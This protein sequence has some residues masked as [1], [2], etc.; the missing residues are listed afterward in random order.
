MDII[1]SIKNIDTELF[2]FL[3]SKHSHF[4]DVAMYWVT[5]RFF[6]IP[7]YL[8]LFYLAFKQVGKRIWLLAIFAALLILLSDQLSVHAF[9]NVFLR[10]RPCHNLLIQHQVHLLNGHCGG[11]YGFISSHATNTFALAMFLFLF[12]KNKMKRFGIFI[13]TWATVVSYSR[14]Y[15]GVH[16]PADLAVGA[17]VGMG[18][19]ISVFK[20]Y[21]YIDSIL[22]KEV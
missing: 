18:I 8:F 19:G 9:K 22:M 21:Y 3:N 10:Y 20:I 17:I 12:F 16:Y 6:W 1:N 15:S 5:N 7:L 2:L 11:T 13:F 4:F 14:I